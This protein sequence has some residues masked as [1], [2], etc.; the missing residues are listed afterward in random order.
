MPF[1]VLLLESAPAFSASV[2]WVDEARRPPGGITVSV[3]HSTLNCKEG[4]A[5]TNTLPVVRQ[6]PMVAGVDGA[7]TVLESSPRPGP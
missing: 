1:K 6:W 5:I 7:G 2:R 4:L 3:A